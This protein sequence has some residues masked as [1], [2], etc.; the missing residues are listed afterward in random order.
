M[1]LLRRRAGALEAD[2]KGWTPEASDPFAGA[3]D[4]MRLRLDA[5]ESDLAGK[6]PR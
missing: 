5:V 2:L 4:E 6:R 3:L 1:D